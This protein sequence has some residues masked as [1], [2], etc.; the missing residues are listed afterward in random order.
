T[1]ARQGPAFPRHRHVHLDDIAR[2]RLGEIQIDAQLARPAQVGPQRQPPCEQQQEGDPRQKPSPPAR[3]LLAHPP[4]SSPCLSSFLRGLT[5][6]RICGSPLGLS[7]T[8]AFTSSVTLVRSFQ[9]SRLSVSL[10][11]KRRTSCVTMR[12]TSPRVRSACATRNA[13]ASLGSFISPTRLRMPS[14]VMNRA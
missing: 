9:I 7:C 5:R 11:R 3:G 1:A 4:S 14:S 10:S 2:Q 13:S 12:V 8:V 6:A